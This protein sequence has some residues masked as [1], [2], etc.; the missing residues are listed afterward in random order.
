M[1]LFHFGISSLIMVML[2][3]CVLQLQKTNRHA[4]IHQ[5]SLRSVRRCLMVMVGLLCVMLLS[6]VGRLWHASPG[7][8]AM[9]APL[10]DTVMLLFPSYFVRLLLRAYRIKKATVAEFSAAPD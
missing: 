2:F 6:S 7:W 1:G 8:E 4:G 10:I 3:Y 9:T 5:P